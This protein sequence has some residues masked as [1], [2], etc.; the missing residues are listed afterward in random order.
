MMADLKEPLLFRSTKSFMSSNKANPKGL[1]SF[2][3]LA[4][5]DD[6]VDGRVDRSTG[7]AIQL[8]DVRSRKRIVI[9]LVFFND[10]DILSA[11]ERMHSSNGLF[12]FAASSGEL[13]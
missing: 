13:S 7:M 8:D 9:T 1:I 5:L 3:S 2:A 11:E 6:L 12:L 4:V 10:R